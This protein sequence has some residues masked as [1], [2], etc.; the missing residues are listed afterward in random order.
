MITR[1]DVLNGS[2]DS[3]PLGD[4]AE[5][6]DHLR[7]PVTARDRT[8]G[9][10]PYY[11]A[12]GQQ[13]TIGEYIFDEPLVLLAEDGGY[14]DDPERGVAYSISG[15]TWVNNHAHVLRA[16]PDV[17]LRFL[18]RILEHY[19]LRPFV[20]G[21]TRG[22]LTKSAASQIPVPIPSLDEQR[23]LAAILDKAAALRRNRGDVRALLD[24]LPRETFHMMFSDDPARDRKPLKSLTTLITKGT[25][26]TS[27]G[28]SFSDSGVPFIRVQNLIGGTVQF[29]A[30][31]LF[32]NQEAHRA[33]S[34]SRVRPGDLL[35]SIAG[36]IGRCAIVP[37]DTPE[38]N[39]NQAVAIV[40]L[41]DPQMA[42]IIM[43]WFG[44][45]DALQQVA[46]SSVT[47]TI[48]NLS[49][50]QL[51]A[52]QVP[53]FNHPQ[54]HEFNGRLEAVRGVQQTTSASSV[55]LDQLLGSL[56]IRAFSGRL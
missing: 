53:I 37:P 17:N 39:C 24:M 25:T 27:V 9:D 42:P 22:K 21:T 14:F 30:G 5:F 20:T 52:L 19:D 12:N 23:R 46:S 43:T 1:E 44:T 11:G 35:V 34:R 15:R 3:R 40:R 47:A 28:L 38:M 49:L 32:V 6:L 54:L 41:I 55:V 50:S 29:G 31:D 4:V 48:S 18:T 36:T 2:Y 16:K 56:K 8:L 13:G 51:G 45:S 26:P 10:Y 7:K 33:L